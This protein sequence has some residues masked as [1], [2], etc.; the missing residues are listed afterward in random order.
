MPD[1]RRE[2]KAEMEPRNQGFK[3]LI[4]GNSIFLSNPRTLEPLNPL[5]LII[6]S[7]IVE[8][9]SGRRDGAFEFSVR[10]EE[11][12]EVRHPVRS[13]QLSTP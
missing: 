12:S 4:P 1:Y 3:C 13:G 8:I 6:F 7:H 5:I 10:K 2:A 11:K 9:F